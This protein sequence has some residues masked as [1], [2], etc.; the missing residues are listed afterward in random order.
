M[1]EV[2]VDSSYS[3]GLALRSGSVSWPQGRRKKLSGG[4][5]GAVYSVKMHGFTCIAKRRIEG[6]RGG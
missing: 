5:Y 2:S 1:A 6:G 3:D 4:S